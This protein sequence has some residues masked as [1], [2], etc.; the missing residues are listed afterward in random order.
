MK[1][2]NTCVNCAGLKCYV[3]L[4]CE[5]NE[6][7]IKP[8]GILSESEDANVTFQVEVSAIAKEVFAEERIL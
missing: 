4:E 6:L 1:T 5:D 3:R 8:Q 7:P 2:E